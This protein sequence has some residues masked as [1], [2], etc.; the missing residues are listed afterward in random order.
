MDDGVACA[1]R[2]L[3]SRALVLMVL[4]P[5]IMCATCSVNPSPVLVAVVLVH[6]TGAGC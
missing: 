3:L 2:T 6:A 5:P 4:A 1:S